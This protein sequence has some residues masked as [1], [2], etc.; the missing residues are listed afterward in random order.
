[1]EKLF[2]YLSPTTKSG[3]IKRQIVTYCQGNGK[4]SI[5]DIAKG[6]SYSIPTINKYIADLTDYG[7]LL[8]YGK[9]ET[10]EGR[11]PNMYGVNPDSC[12]FVGVDIRMF[13]LCVGIINF[14]GELL[15]M[16]ED[17]KFVFNDD[18]ETLDI[19]CKETKSFID[20]LKEDKSV[21]VDVA[22]IL[23]INVNITGRVNPTTGYSY[24][25][26]NSGETPLTDILSGQ[27][28]YN[29]F[30]DNDSRAM[31]YGEYL[32]YYSDKVSDML[33]I[34]IS[35]GLGMGIV[36][37]GKLY[38]GKS[39]FS[40][41]LGHTCVFD[42]ELICH[43]GKK[44]CLET[45]AS[46]QAL[47]RELIANI[48]NGSRSAFSQAV[49]SEK[50]FTLEDIVDAAINKE[51]VLCIEIIEDIGQK[52]GKQVAN[53]INIFNPEAII[54]GGSLS[55]AGDY[56]L[57]PIKAAVR[58]YSLN[59]VSND[60]VVRMSRLQEKAGVIGACLLARSKV[61]ESN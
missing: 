10:K 48:K 57:L 12:Y 50:D 59:L 11:H 32:S 15:K 49:A 41:E 24:S 34:N 27:L 55:R 21:N 18:R 14:S 43:C 54:I 20:S 4:S 22:K 31:T 36:I 47:K 30:I 46:G 2:E 25:C 7:F 61:L 53:L 35:W 17:T 37:N 58:K 23:S 28:G 9:I 52:L 39:G 8:D 51:D 56:L 44:G 5:P 6:L 26:F 40:G 13:S 60:T 42:N 38:G 45:E 19:I 1:M 33:F 29:V 16:N 3:Q